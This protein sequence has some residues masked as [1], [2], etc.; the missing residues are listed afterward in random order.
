MVLRKIWLDLHQRFLICIAIFLAIVF[1]HIGIFPYLKG[2]TPTWLPEMSDQDMGYVSRM[3]QDY[4]FYSDLRWFQEIQ[5]LALFAIVLSLG[6]VL[7]EAKTR[8]I[9]ISLSLPVSRRKWLT[10]QAGVVAVIVLSVSLLASILLSVG[11]S[12]VGQSY[13]LGHSLWGGILLTVCVLPWVGITLLA[14]AITGDHLKA[15]L[16]ALGLLTV[17]SFLNRIPGLDPWLPATLMNSIYGESFYW[18]PLLTILVV[19]SITLFLAIRRFE[20]TDF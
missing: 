7:T 11:G 18:K 1:L 16:I 20:K 4:A 8:S 14:T 2:Y 3:V 5:R 9:L 17:A 13:S 19:T 10:F 15:V 6:G 12:V